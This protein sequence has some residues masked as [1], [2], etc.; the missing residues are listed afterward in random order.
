MKLVLGSGSPRR[1][2]I[3]AAL[4]FTFR[5][6][7]PQIDEAPH[8]EEPWRKYLD[9]VVSEKLDAV[10]PLAKG[11]LILVADTS[12][13]SEDRILGKPENDLDGAAMLRSLSG[14]THLVA[15]RFSLA[16]EDEVHS[17]TIVTEVEMR[18]ID[19]H[20]IRHYVTTGE[21]RDKAGAYAIQGGASV[22]VRSIRG[23]YTNVVGLP[24][25]EVKDA[26]EVYR[27]RIEG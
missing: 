10:R 9:R 27:S 6:I 3:L 7:V 26:L 13:I 25:C 23:S 15:T 14:K 11:A 12:V 17:E 22:F 20:E 1:K 16:T 8:D 18:A 4:G 2:E 24:A 21:G 5:E 19:E